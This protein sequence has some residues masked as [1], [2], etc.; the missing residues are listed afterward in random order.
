[1]INAILIILGVIAVVLACEALLLARIIRECSLRILTVHEYGKYIKSVA[2]GVLKALAVTAIV[3]VATVSVCLIKGF[4]RGSDALEIVV[5]EAAD[6][7]SEKVATAKPFEAFFP[8]D[9]LK[10][11]RYGRI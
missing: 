8:S 2:K 6:A 9:T 11:A 4:S 1:M 10:E 5:L 7:A 3:I